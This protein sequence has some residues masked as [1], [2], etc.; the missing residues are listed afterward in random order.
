MTTL[1]FLGAGASQPFG[2]PTMT[3]MVTKFEERLK[4][5]NIKGQYLYSAIKESLKEGFDISQIDIESIF[6]V[7]IGIAKEIQP[8][9]MGY[10][11][12]YYLNK[13]SSEH[14]FSPSEIDE[15]KNLRNELEK[16][17]Q[18]ECK[19]SNESIDI[20]SL[21]KN[22]FDSLFKNIWGLKKQ[23][24][25]KEQEYFVGWK[26]Y[27]TNYDTIFESYWKELKPPLDYFNRNDSQ[28]PYFDST[29]DILNQ[30]NTFMKLHG[31]IDWTV[32]ENGEILEDHPN[33]YI[34]TKRKGRAMLYP[35]QQ[36]DLYLHPWTTLFQNLLYGLKSCDLWYV[37]GYAFNDEY[38]LNAFIEAFS[39]RKRMIILNPHAKNLVKK[40]PEKFH[41]Q[42]TLLPI[43]FGNETFPKQF[44]DFFHGQ[45]TLLCKIT[46]KSKII[47]LTSNFR[48]LDSKMIETEKVKLDEA[49]V[50]NSEQSWIKFPV[51]H[52]G[53]KEEIHL[54]IKS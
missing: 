17:I 6:S 42:I 26:V 36:K 10:Y 39:D 28:T 30:Q 3:Q 16:F 4:K 13:F 2:I 15:A 1:L 34:R 44:E 38:V 54:L 49:I 46:T 24:N 53:D 51:L 8:Q 5:E 37:I 50:T 27:T 29:R 31:S 22:S 35:I 11:P 19:I 47:G 25:P 14:K 9:K 12:Y 45:K 48:I 52:S 18:I 41:Q 7:I 32:L 33:L 21:Y 20:D 43:K 40:L 23:V